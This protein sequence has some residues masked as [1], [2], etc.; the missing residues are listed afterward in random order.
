MIEVKSIQPIG[1][2][3]PSAEGLV[4]DHAPAVSPEAL[5]RFLH[6]MDNG[7]EPA[8]K[9][10]GIL[11]ELVEQLRS[12]S[13]PVVP[14][15]VPLKPD[16]VGATPELSLP[17]EVSKESAGKQSTVSVPM[18]TDRTQNEAASDAGNAIVAKEAPAI[19]NPPPAVKGTPKTVVGWHQPVGQSQVGDVKNTVVPLPEEQFPIAETADRQVVSGIYELINQIP[20]IKGYT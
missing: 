15:E 13:G 14:L 9:P 12:H 3:S 4:A 20:V 7:A 8:G 10:S 1:V 16:G 17:V 6:Y 19:N 18:R 5:R 11:R 2:S